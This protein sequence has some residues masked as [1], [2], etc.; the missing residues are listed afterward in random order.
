MQHPP[1][2]MLKWSEMAS[3]TGEVADHDSR[4]ENTRKKYD[5]NAPQLQKE[6]VK[7]K[8]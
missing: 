1:A 7:G 3:D 2:S 8:D 6:S 5:I 4:L